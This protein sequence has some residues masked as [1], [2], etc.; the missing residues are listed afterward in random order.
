[1]A[2]SLWTGTP[3]AHFARSALALVDE[4][5]RVHTHVYLLA[6][7]TKDCPLP[8][9]QVRKAFAEGLARN[10][11]TIGAVANVVEGVGFRSAA[12]RG[13]LTSMAMLIQA[14]Y[15][16]KAS[17][18]TADAAAFLREHGAIEARALVEAVETM[19]ETEEP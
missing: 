15:P 12:L 4:L 2:I 13:V 7:L 1:M 16:Q 8:D 6:V 3:R 19:R 9:D 11:G 14:P 5:S 17:A 18:T 10:R